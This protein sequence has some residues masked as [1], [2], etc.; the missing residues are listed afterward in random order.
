MIYHKNLIYINA[1]DIVMN[2]YSCVL[3]YS[4]ID[5]QAKLDKDEK[6]KKKEKY[7]ESTLIR[8]IVYFFI[9]FIM[10]LR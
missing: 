4:Q 10:F 8:Q 6:K 7:H 2:S 5:Y 9:F 1:L 3:S